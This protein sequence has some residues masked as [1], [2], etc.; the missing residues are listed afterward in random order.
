MKNTLIK[1]ALL[2]VAIALSVFCILRWKHTVVDPPQQLEFDNFHDKELEKSI[3]MIDIDS[4]ENGYFECM[5]KLRRYHN[6]GLIDNSSADSHL[7][8]LLNAY[9]PKFII[10]SN[11]TFNNSR[12]DVAPW[13]HSFMETR[14]KELKQIKKLDGASAIE[15]SS[16]YMSGLNSILAVI[17]K[18]DAAWQLARKTE[19]RSIATTKERVA[20]AN[21]YKNDNKLKKCVALVAA[22]NDLPAKIK[23]NHMWYLSSL[24]NDLYCA[25][26][27]DYNDYYTKFTD[28]FAKCRVFENYYNSTDTEKIKNACIQRQYGYLKEYV[29]SAL[30]VNNFLNYPHYRSMNLRVKKILDE[31]SAWLEKNNVDADIQ[32]LLDLYDDP[33]RSK[34]IRSSDEF[35]SKRYHSLKLNRTPNFA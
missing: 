25:N 28:F 21:I 22:L 5:Y 11:N 31:Y 16:E 2:T 17:E 4:L 23:I 32:D 15:T 13:D 24:Y 7:E 35:S 18:F 26:L 8:D 3:S 33:A 9:I 20:Q 12:W 30:D 6:E 1:A 14:I 10:K 19:F 34:Y 29:D 27:G